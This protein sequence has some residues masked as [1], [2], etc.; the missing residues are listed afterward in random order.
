[1]I[2]EPTMT[3]TKGGHPDL[4]VKNEKTSFYVE[5]KTSD[6]KKYFEY[7]NKKDIADLLY[8]KVQTCDQLNITFSTPIKI[9]AF[10]EI[11]TY[12]LIHK[13]Q[14]SFKLGMDGFETN[15]EITPEIKLSIIQKPVII[16][17]ES[18]HIVSQLWMYLE[19]D[20]S[21]TRSIGIAFLR[22]G[23]A[24]G[25]FE[26]VDYRN[27]L[28]NKKE[29]SLHQIVDGHANVI[30]LRDSDIVGDPLVNKMYIETEW[31]TES[32]SY[33]SGVALFDTYLE[34]TY[35]NKFENLIFHKNRHAIFPIDI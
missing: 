33:C 10:K 17:K 29:Q 11:L 24:I 9:E 5:C 14:N 3:S 4:L 13:I 2:L 30:F 18:D 27:K 34:N 23:R 12:E 7:E 8:Q 32:L 31:L 15:I 16:G 28:K 6:I 22:G 21:K 25:V 35:G 1:M 19:D 20:K 26:I